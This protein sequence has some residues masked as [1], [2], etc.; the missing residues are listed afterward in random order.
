MFTKKIYRYLII[1]VFAL[2]SAGF[3]LQLVDAYVEVCGNGVVDFNEQCDDL[4]LVDGDGCNA[5]CSIE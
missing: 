2:C 1:F 4:D 3:L 5:V